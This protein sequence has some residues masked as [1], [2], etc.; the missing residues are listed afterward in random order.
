MNERLGRLGLLVGEEGLGALA[1]AHV[2]VVGLGGVG[3]SC[4]LALARSG[5]GE[6]TLIDGDAVEESNFNRQAIANE[7]TLG[8][9]KPE[10]AA[11]LIAAINPTIAVHQVFRRVGADE[12][13]EVI[14]A[15]CDVVIDCVDDLPVKIALAKF[16]AGQQFLL[17]SCMGTARKWHPEL[18]RFADINNTRVCPVAKVMRRELKRAGV[19]RLTVLYSEEAPAPQLS[20]EPRPLG[21]TA[22]V[23]PVAGTMLAGYAVRR[24][25]GVE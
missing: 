23:P 17:L 11:R 9:P 12:L 4:A 8:L 5:V 19:D 1:R 16:A 10:A 22:F 18:L 2:C 3:G 20:E 21:S 7:G 24:I 14:P 25:L 13:A 6:L 15:G